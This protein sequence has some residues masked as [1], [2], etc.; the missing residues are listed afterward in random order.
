MNQPEEKKPSKE[1]NIIDHQK[2][3]LGSW[4]Y[5]RANGGE[6]QEQVGARNREMYAS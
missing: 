2:L 3:R 4:T 5:T 1:M 6:V